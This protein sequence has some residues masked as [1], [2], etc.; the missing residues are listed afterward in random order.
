MNLKPI[1]PYYQQR[2]KANIR[3][4]ALIRNTYSYPFIWIEPVVDRTQTDVDRAKTLLSKS[5]E[6]FTAEEKEA[7]L[8]GLKG[9]MNRADFERIENNIQILLDVL[10]IDSSSYVEAVPEFPTSAYFEQMRDNIASIRNG[11]A[12]HVDTPEVPELPFNTWQKFNDI[13][14]ILADVYE[15]VASQLR[16][17]AGSE[18]YAGD[19]VGLLL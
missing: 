11:Y 16:Y 6:E 13:E 8:S 4:F 7:Y 15:V 19:T 3:T 12:V 2:V 9:C 14:K 5:W 10:E 1:N 18:I 17:Y